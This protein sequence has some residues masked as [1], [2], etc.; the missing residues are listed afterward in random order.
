MGRGSGRSKPAANGKTKKNE[1][2]EAKKRSIFDLLTDAVESLS[3]AAGGAWGGPKVSPKEVDEHFR[4]TDGMCGDAMRDAM[5]RATKGSASAVNPTGVLGKIGVLI[6]SFAGG[7][8][9]DEVQDR[10]WD[11]ITRN[12]S[13]DEAKPD[14]D[15]SADTCEHADQLAVD[16]G[17]ELA[18]ALAEHIRA[19]S[20]ALSSIDPAEN[21]DAFAQL[22][23]AGDGLIN[24]GMLALI[25]LA[26]DRD[27]CIADSYNAILASLGAICGCP[28][29]PIPPACEKTADNSEDTCVAQSVKSTEK[30]TAEVE[31]VPAGVEKLAAPTVAEA[32]RAPEKQPEQIPTEPASADKVGEKTLEKPAEKATEKAC[33]C[34]TKAETKAET[35]T[36]KVEV[37]E[38][39]GCSSTTEAASVEQH[40]PTDSADLTAEAEAECE[41]DRDSTGCGLGVAVAV[42]LAIAAI[43]AL[44]DCAIEFCAAQPEPVAEPEPAPPVEPA[45]QVEPAAHQPPPPP[46]TDPAQEPPAPPKKLVPPPVDHEPPPPPK[47]SV[48][49]PAP[50]PAAEPAL[51]GAGSS[52][53]SSAQLHKAGAW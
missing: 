39:C 13:D 35:A 4:T 16:T 28:T 42:G 37:K 11:W 45:P 52:V 47:Q 17:M 41:E 26:N 1:D 5:G 12:G 14:N 36:E 31:T 30:C 24:E 27:R 53:G 7:M 38:T 46:I 15:T 2:T 21:P 18:K 8:V 23:A 22:V 29:E 49:E 48:P 32:P 20:T 51:V 9:V 19:I 34:A 40:E 44:I 50:A 33:G 10:I 3:A 6:A 25:G 43:G